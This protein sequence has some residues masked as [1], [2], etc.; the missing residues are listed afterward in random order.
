M[1]DFSAVNAGFVAAAY[2]LSFAVLVGLVVVTF[3]KARAARNR[4]K[5]Q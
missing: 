2:S 5:D 4:D 1:F 3:L